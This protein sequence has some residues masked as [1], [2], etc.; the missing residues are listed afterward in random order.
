MK[1][2]YNLI[3]CS[4]FFLGISSSFAQTN[5]GPLAVASHNGG[6]QSIFGYGPE[7]YNDN[8]IPLFGSGMTFQWGW[9]NSNGYIDYI[10][11]M[12]VTITQVVFHN[13][14]RP[15]T[16]LNIEYW[17]GSAYVT[18]MT[19]VTNAALQVVTVNLPSQVI[20]SRLRFSNIAGSNPNFREIETRGWDLPE[21]NV[22]V[23]R[24]VN[25]DTSTSFCSGYNRV[26][27]MVKNLGK[28]PVSKFD[29]GW[30]FNN[31]TYG[32]ITVNA[33]LPNSY[34][35][36][37]VDLDYIDFPY[38]VLSNFVAYA[39]NPNNV[40]DE[41]PSDDTITVPVIATKQG[42]TLNVLND[43]FLCP[44]SSID[45]DAG[46][47]PNTGY[48]WSN[49]FQSN[50]TTID[51]I[52]TYW[53]YA[54]ST[55]GCIALDTF[56]VVYPPLLK[57]N[58]NISIID[59]KENLFLF[60]ISNAENVLEYIWDFGD[61]SPTETGMGPK[62]HQYNDTG[63]FNVML[64]MIGNCDTIV[65][66]NNTYVNSLSIENIQHSGLSIVPN[67]ANDFIKIVN[68]HNSKI[69][70]IL[71]YNSIGQKVMETKY[72]EQINI[73]HFTNG[74]YILVIQTDKG[75]FRSKFNKN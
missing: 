53:I 57:A 5:I 9:V 30:K 70:Q 14:N 74:W 20:T 24:L 6:G 32:P 27:V 36:V 56:E 22:G 8:N 44:G 65:L 26:K 46:V 17:N 49:G 48:T 73:G 55:S 15:F 18:L 19:G 47:S 68:N 39:Y 61:G 41:K 63:Y 75:V 1:L 54:Y 67:P 31:I 50:I 38:N 35:S 71:I 37:I 62:Q 64:T 59:L 2:I 58:E 10:W 25:P 11:P 66:T 43:T 51:T 4:F 13:D 40:P 21:N 69:D 7:L 28:N 52:G 23:T 45:I 72:K 29:I 42:V 34:D 16:S 33:S 12:D 3:F 60:N